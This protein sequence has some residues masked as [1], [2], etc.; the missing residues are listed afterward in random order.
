MKQKVLAFLAVH[1]KVI[2]GTLTWAVTFIV[3][4]NLL[5]LSG[6]DA[7]GLAIALGIPG[8]YFPR[9]NKPTDKPGA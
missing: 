4:H 3:S 2:I 1:R 5:D 9:N 6:N 7:A 8:I